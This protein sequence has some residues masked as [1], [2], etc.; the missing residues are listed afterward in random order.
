M[1]FIA[2]SDSASLLLCYCS[3]WPKT[4]LEEAHY[5]IYF[6]CILSLIV[7]FTK[8]VPCVAVNIPSELIYNLNTWRVAESRVTVL[9]L[10][11]LSARPLGLCCNHNNECIL[12]QQ[13]A[14]GV[15]ENRYLNAGA[16]FYLCDYKSSYKHT[17]FQLFDRVWIK[18]LS[19]IFTS[20]VTNW[21]SVIFTLY[22]LY[23]HS[24]TPIS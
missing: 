2:Y 21:L 18:S 9:I 8:S 23:Q 22:R 13:G 4:W 1:I 14:S 3:N 11:T 12:H 5:L 7:L 24:C 17:P 16:Y 19:I 6:P 10:S 15:R 20:N